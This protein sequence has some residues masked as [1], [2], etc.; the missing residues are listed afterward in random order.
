L[1][2]PSGGSI[3]IDHTEALISIDINSSRATKGEDIEATAL[4]TNLEAADEIARQLR[5]RDLGGLI[6]I[7]F[8]DMTPARNQREVENRLREAVKR[9]RARIQLGRISR[10]GLLEMSR[11]RLRPSL[12]ESSHETCPR[13]SGL[14]AIRNVESLALSIL[15]IIEEEAM[16]E[17]TARI[18][19]QLPVNVATYLLN[20]KRE[21]VTQ[22]EKRQGVKLVLIANTAL[23]TP[24]FE[25]NRIRVDE[26]PAEEKVSYELAK[27]VQKPEEAA[28]PAQKQ[29]AEKPMV[30]GV[31]PS[32]PMP[33]RS[34]AAARTQQ[35]ADREKEGGFIK[36]LFS[37]IFGGAPKEEE[38]PV[39]EPKP[40]RKPATGRSR[41]TGGG[42]GGGGGRGRTSGT[43]GGAQQAAGS[44]SSSSR[45][46]G[47]RRRGGQ[48][49][50]GGTAQ[51][52]RKSG[53][54]TRQEKDQ[55]AAT[56]ANGGNQAQQQPAPQ[57]QSQES[58][59]AAAVEPK[60]PQ[61]TTEAPSAPTSDSGRESQAPAAS[62]RPP[63]RRGGGG[64]GRQQQGAAS[65]EKRAEQKEQDKAAPQP[66]E[67]AAPMPA[68][69]EAPKPDFAPSPVHNAVART[70]ASEK[71]EPQQ[72]TETA[73]IPPSESKAENKIP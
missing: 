49:R 72:K 21:T 29:A 14:G 37:S 17:N 66:Q 35:E 42:G 62:R 16:K 73:A 64:R 11:Q 2:L 18:V 68:R 45:S 26:L 59:P 9:D 30:K 3:V 51:R 56:P 7:D 61:A 19:C 44:G 53:A 4:N 70:V 10:F 40:Q 46:R 65:Q 54:E 8:I 1:S 28:L 25:V 12:G 22:I 5:L 31:M 13:C 60:A 32:T 63:R 55:A 67:K 69:N 33:S 52:Q 36:Q 41:R 58:K 71:K 38:A 43:G 57:A 27:E 48:S 24:A 34:P 50:R 23:E 20:E 15:R 39:E 6:V 47:G